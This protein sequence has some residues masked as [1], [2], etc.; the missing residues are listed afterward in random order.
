[1]SIRKT[2]AGSYYIDIRAR[3]PTGELVRVRQTLRKSKREAQRYEAMIRAA[4]LNGTWTPKKPDADKDKTDT[5]DLAPTMAQWA[6]RFIVEHSE[7]KGLR[8]GTIREQRSI[9]KNYI[10]P[11]VGKSTRVDTIRTS[12]FDK[13]R[14]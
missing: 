3:K 13:V 2:A 9:L 7:A 11:A 8:I 1:M 12:H 10:L 14:R 4:I 5:A 6:D